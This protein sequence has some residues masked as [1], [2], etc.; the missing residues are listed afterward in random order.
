MVGPDGFLYV[1]SI[2]QGKVFRIFPSVVTSQVE[3]IQSRVEQRMSAASNT[4]ERNNGEETLP[5]QLDGQSKSIPTN[6]LNKKL[7]VSIEPLKDAVTRG[8]SQSITISSSSN[9]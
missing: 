3:N 6:N 9:I 4:I 1:V 8:G 2:G 7:H 5:R